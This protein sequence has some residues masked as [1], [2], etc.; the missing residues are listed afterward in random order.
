MRLFALPTETD[1]RER[2]LRR[3]LTT[4]RLSALHEDTG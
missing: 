4:A 3:A 2:E 1:Y